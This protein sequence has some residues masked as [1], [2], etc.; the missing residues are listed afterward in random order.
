MKLKIGN[1]MVFCLFQTGQNNTSERQLVRE[2][3]TTTL[4]TDCL[5]RTLA[6]THSSCVTL[7]SY[8]TSRCPSFFSGKIGMMIIST[9]QAC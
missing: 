3:R 1:C 9:S 8:I 6:V 7:A 4:Q 2:L 5:V